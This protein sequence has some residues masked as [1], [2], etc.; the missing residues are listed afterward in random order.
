MSI[1]S[2]DTEISIIIVNYNGKKYIDNLMSSLKCQ[3]FQSSRFEIVFVDNNS[4][5]DSVKY[6]EKNWLCELKNLNIVRSSVNLGFAGG[7]NLGVYNAK[8]KYIV[9]L[10]NDTKPNS[11]WLENLYNFFISKKGIVIANSLLLFYYDFI[12]I[13]FNT[14]DKFF[15]SSKI[16]INETDYIIDSK[17]CKNLLYNQDVLTCFGHTEIYIPLINGVSDYCIEINKISGL[18]SDVIIVG[19][20]H[21]LFDNDIKINI[22][23]DVVINNQKTLVQNAG[24]GINE[25]YD[26]YDIGFTEE[27]C[28]KYAKPYKITNACGASMMIEKE[29]FIEIGGFDKS[30]F[31]YYEDTDLSFRAKNGGKEIWYCPDSVVRH[32][33]TGSSKEWSPFFIY[34]VTKNKL[35]F[36]YKNISKKAYIKYLIYQLMDGIKS[37][38][39]Y[40]IKGSLK[41]LLIKKGRNN[42]YNE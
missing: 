22:S 30:F 28:E 26:G 3:T 34:H 8:G 1:N 33:H 25:N 37:K 23:R 17:F 38:N 32:I 36:I 6:I 29:K 9:F 4:E 13:K 24:S 5:D 11:D 21:Y 42:A 20:S 41:T 35:L 14:Q 10:N 15:I 27:Y 40:K 2:Y 16:K 31:M 7:N 39:I 18:E 12:K 19:E